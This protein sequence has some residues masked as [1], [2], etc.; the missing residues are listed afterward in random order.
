MVSPKKSGAS[1]KFGDGERMPSSKVCFIPI[2]GEGSGCVEVEVIAGNLPL[3]ISLKSLEKLHAVLD[4]HRAEIQIMDCGKSLKL[5]KLSTGHIGL[6]LMEPLF[7]A[8]DCITFLS[9]TDHL[10]IS[11]KDYKVTSAVCSLLG[12]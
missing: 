12:R 2:F 11:E 3:L 7:V 8:S 9:A 6:P 10:N 5:V 4:I 1:I